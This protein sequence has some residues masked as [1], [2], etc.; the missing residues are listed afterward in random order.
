[1]PA[2]NYSWI[3]EEPKERL[4]KISSLIESNMQRYELLNFRGIQM[5]SHPD[6]LYNCTRLKIPL[7]QAQN[8][9]CNLFAPLTVSDELEFKNH[10]YEDELMNIIRSLG[11]KDSWLTPECMYATIVKSPNFK[12]ISPT[13]KAVLGRFLEEV[14]PRYT[15]LKLM[16]A[17]FKELALMNESEDEIIDLIS[18]FYK[19]NTDH[20]FYSF[21]VFSKNL[22]PSFYQELLSLEKT[23]LKNIFLNENSLVYSGNNFLVANHPDGLINEFIIAAYLN[24]TSNDFS[25]S[26]IE[27][28]RKLFFFDERFLLKKELFSEFYV[29]FLRRTRA[30]GVASITATSFHEPTFRSPARQAEASNCQAQILGNFTKGTS[31]WIQDYRPQ[32]NLNFSSLKNQMLGYASPYFMLW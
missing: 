2:W 25:T 7:I 16:A 23:N 22:N 6:F 18:L 19:Q 31:E 15:R 5:H 1:M 9:S 26:N 32:N 29:E 28:K 17:F 13:N 3:E 27:Y 20:S 10:S 8:F 11:A 14:K 21:K 12:S 30:C 4:S 24:Q